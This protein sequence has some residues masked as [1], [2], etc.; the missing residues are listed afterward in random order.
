VLTLHA[1]GYDG[2]G[3]GVLTDPADNKGL[4]LGGLGVVVENGEE[5]DSSGYLAQGSY[6][7]GDTRIALS[8][9]KSE[10]DNSAM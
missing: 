8:Y 5:V 3:L 9:G 4:G 2:E 7:F 1:S 6:T 10:I